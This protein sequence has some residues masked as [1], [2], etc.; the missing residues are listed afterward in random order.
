MD[1]KTLEWIPTQ[2]YDTAIDEAY[3]DLRQQ[4]ETTAATIDVIRVVKTVNRI[5]TLVNERNRFIAGEIDRKAA[6]ITLSQS[7]S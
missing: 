2:P 7:E 4:I 5:H 3:S 6:T 1:V